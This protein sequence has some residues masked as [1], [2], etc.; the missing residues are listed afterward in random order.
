[1]SKRVESADSV[2]GENGARRLLGRS[3]YRIKDKICGYDEVFLCEWRKDAGAGGLPA[4][5]E[6][7]AINL[8]LLAEG[9]LRYFEDAE[10]INYLLRAA[11][12]YDHNWESG[13]ALVIR[14]IGPVHF[15]WST[16]YEGFFLDELK[17]RLT[18]PVPE[19]VMI[20]DCWTP[21]AVRGQ[22]YYRAAIGQLAK[23]LSSVGKVPWI[24]TGGQNA[25]L[26]HAIEKA[27][28]ERR[29]SWIRRKI[30]GWQALRKS[31]SLIAQRLPIHYRYTGEG[32]VP[33]SATD[34]ANL[35]NPR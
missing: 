33:L 3:V 8:D 13:F 10:T 4:G 20:S 22:G 11:Q 34:Q 24:F 7:M 2:L 29:Y 14:G 32:K 19:A 27:G 26:I 17:I 23:R 16:A 12:R 5:F 9:A 21:R 31:P 30:P 25:S 35:K 6:L 18:A 15:C 1:M 28:F